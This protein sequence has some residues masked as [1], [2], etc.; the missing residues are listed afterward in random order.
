MAR[1]ALEWTLNPSEEYNRPWAGLKVYYGTFNG[2]SPRTFSFCV[3][4]Y[5]WNWPVPKLVSGPEINPLKTNNILINKSDV[6]MGEADDLCSA[7]P[8][9]LPFNPS[10]RT[11]SPPSLS[12]GGQQLWLA[13]LS[14]PNP[15]AGSCISALG[16]LQQMCKA[17][18]HLIGWG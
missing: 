1:Q 14:S 8:A 7:A 11:V 3:C 6:P 9:N 15:N 4:L 2:Q 13:A 18:R 10:P 16:T 5:M 17:H 12:P